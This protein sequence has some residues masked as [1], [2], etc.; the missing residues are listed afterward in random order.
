M[1]TRI[2]R[3]RTERLVLDPIRTNDAKALFAIMRA[4][5]IGEALGETP[6]ESQEEVRRRIESWIR[7]PAESDERWLNWL[8]RTDTTEPSPSGRDRKRV[9]GLAG[10][11]R[12]SR[13]P[14]PGLR[15]RG[16]R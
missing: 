15:E 6:P 16:R 13:L 5:V 9:D 4:P 1:E 11:D 14:A 12:R 2:A 7:G 10:V 8:A 3:I